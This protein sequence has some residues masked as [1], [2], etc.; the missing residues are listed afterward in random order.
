MRRALIAVAVLSALAFAGISLHIRSGERGARAEPVPLPEGTA[1]DRRP[2]AVPLL[3]ARGGPTSLADFRGRWLVL[4]P[5]TT[6]CRE[7]CPLTT[8]ALLRL[9]RML[10]A[11][12]AAGRVTVAEL[13]VDPWRDSPERLRAYRRRSGADFPLLTGSP[14]R[15]RRVWGFFGVH[16]ARVPQGRPPDRD[17]LTGRPQRFDVEHTDGLFLIDP[18]GRE[19]VAIAGMPDVGGRLARRLRGLLDREGRANLARPRAAWRPAR[20]FADLR[21]LAGFQPPGAPSPT[22]APSRS[23][24]TRALSGAPGPLAA[25]HRQAGELLGGESLRA[26]LDRLHGYPVVLNAWAS[27]CPPCREE[28]PLFA[29]ASAAR[30]GEVAFLGADLEDDPAAARRLLAGQRL[31]YPS[32]PVDRETL[33]ALA[34]FRG[35]PT[36]IFLSADGDLSG[37]HIG[38]YRSSAE[39][40]ADL[41]RYAPG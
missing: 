16:F 20:V 14:S 37:L 35:T 32:Y 26:R 23:T 5:S 18:R 12:G 24:A 11:A 1:V 21:L 34:P 4:A 7:V 2:P 41:R 33:S 39:L 28:L 30:G 40:S 19:R 36:T 10:R 15:L 9:R 31:S 22:A 13:S 8:G 25:L 6:L 3:D 27:W 38:P 17:W 29:A